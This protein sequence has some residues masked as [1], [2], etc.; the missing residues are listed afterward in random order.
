[1]ALSEVTVDVVIPARNE[2]DCIGRCL[3]SLVSQQ[4]IDFRI[5]VVDDGSTDKTRQIAESFPG[6]RVL[7]VGDPPPGILGKS[8]ALIT[9]V[10]ESTAKWLLFTD[11]DTSHY[12]GSLAAAVREAEEREVDLLSYSP[13]QEAVSLAEKALMPLVFAELVRTYPTERINNPADP[14]VAANG[15]YILVRRTVYEALGGHK[16]VGGNLLEDV[17]LAR[18]FK[19]SGHKIWFRYGGGIVRTRMY[20]SFR[21]LCEGWTK[22][23]ALLFRNPLVLAARRSVEFLVI[24]LALISAFTVLARQEVAL[25]LVLL[26]IGLF[27]YASFL[28]RIH[29]AHFPWA[30]NFIALLG[31]PLF[32]SL[33]LRSYI[34]TNMRAEVTWKGRKYGQSAPQGAADSSTHR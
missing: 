20:R 18:I 11:A 19:G 6:V 23:L 21:A 16:V 29:R 31:L 13:E 33:L 27:L 5:T 24:V 22:G 8:N 34:H 30:A 32:V 2:E 28:F 14:A 26:A 25:G 9:G 10:Q 12:P 4:G 15:Q 7:S 3:A 17:E 1:M